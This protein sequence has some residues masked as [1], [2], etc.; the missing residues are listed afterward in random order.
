HLET[1][2]DPSLSQNL[3]RGRRSVHG[4]NAPALCGEPKRVPPRPARQI[5]RLAGWRLAGRLYY[6]RRR[7]KIQISRRL[8]SQSVALVPIANIHPSRLSR[9]YYSDRRKLRISCFAESGSAAKIAATRFPSDS[10]RA[11]AA[12]HPSRG[13]PLCC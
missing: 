13:S 5:E 1:L 9:V 12:R 10:S 3:D 4:S 2:L 7:L 11:P 6:Q 8:F